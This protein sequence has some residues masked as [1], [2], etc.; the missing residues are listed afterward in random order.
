MKTQTPEWNKEDNENVKEEFKNIQKFWEKKSNW[1]SWNEKKSSKSQIKNEVESF[2][3]RL[4]QI[5]EKY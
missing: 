1:N 5:K 3:N 4:D 2:Y